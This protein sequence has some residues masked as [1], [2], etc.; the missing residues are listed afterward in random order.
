MRR[1]L[2]GGQNGHDLGD[3]GRNER[4]NA[5]PLQECEDFHYGCE[6]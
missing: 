4:L 3:K 2:S 1:T 6:P 5:E